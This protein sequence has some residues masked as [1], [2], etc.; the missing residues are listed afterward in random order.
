MTQNKSPLD[1][2]ESI[3]DLQPPSIGGGSDEIFNHK[4]YYAHA[5]RFSPQQTV[6]L[7]GQ[8]L[9]LKTAVNGNQ[10]KAMLPFSMREGVIYSDDKLEVSCLV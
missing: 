3:N 5:D 7:T 4:F 9:D 2:L 8:T 1:I 6:K 10:W